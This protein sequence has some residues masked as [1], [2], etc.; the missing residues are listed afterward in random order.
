MC[1]STYGLQRMRRLL[2]ASSGL[3]GLPCGE[4]VAVEARAHGPRSPAERALRGD[5]RV[6]LFLGPP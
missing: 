2:R 4:V 6:P 5:A 1:S 3:E